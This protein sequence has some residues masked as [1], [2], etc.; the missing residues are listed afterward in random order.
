MKKVAY[1][2][3][4]VGS[5]SIRVPHVVYE[6]KPGDYIS[7]PNFDIEDYEDNYDEDEDPDWALYEKFQYTYSEEEINKIKSAKGLLC[8]REY[9]PEENI[10]IP[11]S[12]LKLYRRTASYTV[13]DKAIDF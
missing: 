8:S 11:I 4:Y 9:K 1:C 10:F 12:N 2:L 13:R 6:I 3:K 5:K 7:N